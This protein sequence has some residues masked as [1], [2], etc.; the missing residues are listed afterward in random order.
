LHVR[1][2]EP[3][4]VLKMLSKNKESRIEENNNR[5]AKGSS[6]DPAVEKT[7]N[8]ANS[9]SA[10]PDPLYQMLKPLHQLPIGK[11]AWNPQFIRRWWFWPAS[12]AVLVIL[13]YLYPL[14]WDLFA[15]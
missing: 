3:V 12:A 6:G 13:S 7:L 1:I 15:R 14:I 2:G 9:N 4:G 10:A 8:H 5:V 11:N